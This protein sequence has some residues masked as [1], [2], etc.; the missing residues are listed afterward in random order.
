MHT[1]YTFKCLCFILGV[2]HKC[3]VHICIS[4]P[5]CCILCYM[6]VYCLHVLSTASGFASRVAEMDLR[7]SNLMPSL[8]GLLTTPMFL[9]RIPQKHTVPVLSV[10]QM[11]LGA[12]S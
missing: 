9:M 3:V 2:R 4:R 5:I 6:C 11:Q 10:A 12:A 8:V 7:M 1:Q